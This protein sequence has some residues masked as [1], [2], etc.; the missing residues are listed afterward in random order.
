MT[1][2]LDFGDITP[3]PKYKEKY[4][5]VPG[6]THRIAIIWPKD[7]SAS[8]GPFAV[9]DTH[10]HEQNFLCKGG[11]CCDKLGPAAQKLACIIVK[12]K[13]RKDGTL[14]KKDGEAIPFDF[15]VMEWVFS[16]KKFGTLKRLH[17]DWDLKKND[18]T[19]TCEGDVKFQNLTFMPC[20]ESLWQL[21]SNIKDA[22]YKISESMREH[23]KRALGKDLSVEEI[24]ALFGE[25]STQPTDVI[26][27]EKDLDDIL[28]AV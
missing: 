17:N 12:Y 7:P 3:K 9:G 15:E 6:E 18:F 16:D 2:F 26:S 5:G 23:L 4:K 8:K 27:S 20:K 13:T 22:V 11:F 14:I 24:K 25:G 19:V 28:D 21:K 10:F 1:D